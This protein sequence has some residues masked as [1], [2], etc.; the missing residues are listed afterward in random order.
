M[1]DQPIV[2]ESP[3]MPDAPSQ[4]V[5]SFFSS[6]STGLLS[7][8]ALFSETLL[9]L[10]IKDLKFHDFMREVLI[11]IMKIIKSEAGS[12]LEVDEKK[13]VLFF[14]SVVGSS[15]DRIPQFIVPLG[16]G[17]VGQVAQ[18]RQGIRVNA[19]EE[20]DV[21]LKSI[22]D[23]VGF[24]ARNVLAVPVVIRG[25][26]FGVIELLNRV[27]AENYSPEDMDLCTYLSLQSAKAI[28]ARLILA[29]AL[30][31]SAGNSS[32]MIQKAA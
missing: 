7:C 13:G 5:G 12:I 23:A 22:E 17:L 21:Y 1:T 10:I 11:S 27:G 18:N 26:T 32:G 31:N 24:K 15:S 25:K 4:E 19:M 28:E 14:R 6:E 16:K 30:Q 3:P 29:W 2:L 20:N 9:E 8:K